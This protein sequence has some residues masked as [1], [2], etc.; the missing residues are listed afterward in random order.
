[1]GR[2]C[3]L[4]SEFLR[5]SLDFPKVVG[6]LL[7]EVIRM[8]NRIAAALLTTAILLSLAG[9]G[10]QAAKEISDAENQRVSA[11]VDTKAADDGNPAVDTEQT[12]KKETDA[13]SETPAGSAEKSEPSESTEE[14]ETSVTQPAE[15]KPQSTQTEQP[16]NTVEPK[17]ETVPA[18]TEPQSEETKP[19][20]TT[21]P[22]TETTEPPKAEKTT[23]ETESTEPVVTEPPAA[24]EPTEETLPTVTA[25]PEPTEKPAPF[26]ID[27]WI[28]YAR[29]CA[30][31]NG[32]ILSDTAVDC[33]D[34]PIRA[35]EHCT[36]LERDIQSR[37]NRYA[38]DEDITDVWIWAEAVGND[39]YDIYIGYA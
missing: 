20:E 2:R 34:N 5:S 26:D 28:A 23:P 15:T 39:C 12:E 35:G 16:A 33:W 30:E 29:S 3:K 13:Q 36:Y 19:A 10:H 27:H 1:M 17:A 21:P 6:I 18:V 25:E 37:L 8:K 22:Q 31:S 7:V 11:A 14:T 38:K 32:L 24:T 4:F 9:C